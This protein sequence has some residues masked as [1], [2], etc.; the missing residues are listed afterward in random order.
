MKISYRAL[1]L[2]KKRL[3]MSL[4]FSGW[5]SSQIEKM[6]LGCS[7]RNYSKS[8]LIFR[9]EAA[10]EL[11]FILSG[12]AWSCLRNEAG[13]VRFGMAHPSSLLGLSRIIKTRYHDEPRYEFYAAEDVEILSISRSSFEDQLERDPILWKNA[14]EASIVNQRHCLKMALML[15]AGTVKERVISAIYHFALAVPRHSS[16][17]PDLEMGMQQNDLAILVQTSRQHVNRALQ[18]LQLEGLVKVGYKKIAI[19]DVPMLERRALARFSDNGIFY[20]LA[21]NS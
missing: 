7:I 6:L 4:W 11:I 20:K 15:N 13:A 19:T 3:E 21:S 9:D 17:I 14:A 10:D 8:E 16:R 1:P 2:V 5:S 12:S 18:D